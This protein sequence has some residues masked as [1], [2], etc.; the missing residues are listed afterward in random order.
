MLNNTGKKYWIV[1]EKYFRPFKTW[2]YNTFDLICLGF[3]NFRTAT[4][5]TIQ[6]L[7]G[8]WE[9]VRKSQHLVFQF[10]RKTFWL[11]L[12]MEQEF[13]LTVELNEPR[14]C[15]SVTKHQ[16][17]KLNLVFWPIFKKIKYFSYSLESLLKANLNL[18]IKQ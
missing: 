8:P 15:Q 14:W 4:D 6:G 12:H 1:H 7:G 10:Q 5:M 13:L 9:K 2:C 18:N 16:A 3:K 11:L 17:S